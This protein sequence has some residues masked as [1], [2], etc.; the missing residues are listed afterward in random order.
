MDKPRKA[1]QFTLSRSGTRELVVAFLAWKLLLLALACASPGLGYD[2]S[3]E[4]LL[5]KPASHS[6]S[7]LHDVIQRA[8]LRLTRWD[9][10]YFATLSTRGHVNEQEWAFSWVLARITSGVARGVYILAIRLCKS[11]AK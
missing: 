5:D 7:A 9:G 10:I 11:R 2:T 1:T 8:V 3:T 4:I 6:S